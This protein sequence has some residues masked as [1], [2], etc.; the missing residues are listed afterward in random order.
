[1]ISFASL[2]LAMLAFVGSHFALSHPLRLRLVGQLG[3]QRFAILYSIVAVFTLGWVILAWR[4]RDEELPLWIAPGW[5]WPVASALML[6]ACLLLVGSFVRNPAFPHP[7]S[8]MRLRPATGVFAITR[9]PMNMS[10]ALWALVHLS[11]WGT[12]RNLIVAGGILLLA[13]GGS[14]GQD[15]KK[16]AAIGQRWREW[17]AK[18]SFVPFGALAQG[19]VGWRTATPDWRVLLGGVALW[20]AVTTFHAPA[21][22]PIVWAWQSYG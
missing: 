2:A 16:R 14:T 8:S 4:A 15:R 18:T 7:G 5:W 13:V 17:E 22:S 19:R 9:H 21:V 1:M 12:P 11:L 10:F 6:V 20:L 3:E